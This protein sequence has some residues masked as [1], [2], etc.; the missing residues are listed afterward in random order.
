MSGTSG[1]LTCVYSNHV[2]RCGVL[3]NTCCN[4]SFLHS[5]TMLPGCMLC[6]LLLVCAAAGQH[7][8]PWLAA[9]SVLLVWSYGCAAAAGACT[10]MVVVVWRFMLV[11]GAM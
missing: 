9:S 2:E 1:H 8:A 6:L 5:T 4:M 7:E 10:L 11:V 3:V